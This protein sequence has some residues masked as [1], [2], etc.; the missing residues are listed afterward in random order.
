[1]L[2]A[3]FVGTATNIAI[4]VL[5]GWQWATLISPVFV[6]FRLTKVSGVPMLEEAADERW[7]G[8]DEYEAYKRNTPVLLM[9]PPARSWNWRRRCAAICGSRFAPVAS[10][11]CTIPRF[12]R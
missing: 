11:R 9:K 6:F 7:G 3:A 1:M 12:G 10:G 8:Q 4:P 2:L 5:E